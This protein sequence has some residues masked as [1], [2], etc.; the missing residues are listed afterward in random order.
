MAPTVR[1]EDEEGGDSL[2]RVSRPGTHGLVNGRRGRHDHGDCD[3][4]TT[5]LTTVTDHSGSGRG[6]PIAAV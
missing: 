1:R 3:G 2:Q 5:N 4:A 6:R